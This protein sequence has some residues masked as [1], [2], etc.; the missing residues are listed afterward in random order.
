MMTCVSASW[1]AARRKAV[2]TAA[3]MVLEPSVL[4]GSGAE[5]CEGL[6]LAAHPGCEVT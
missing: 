6:L 3:V 5:K 4:P 1:L 2:P